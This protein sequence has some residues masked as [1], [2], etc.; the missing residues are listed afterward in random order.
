MKININ[1]RSFLKSSSIA[2]AGLAVSQSIF[3]KFSFAETKELPLAK[4]SDAVAKQLKY[5]EDADKPSKNCETRK[6]KD[7]KDQY[8]HGCQLYTK[9]AGEGKTEKG[10]CMI[11]PA[12]LVAGKGW[13]MS[14]VKK[15]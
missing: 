14:W 9:T 3:S 7:K 13:C 5:C 6:A 8:C 10:K 15:P 4:E 12:N 11:M 1:R 2:V